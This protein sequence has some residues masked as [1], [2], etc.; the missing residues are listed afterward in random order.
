MHRVAIAL[1]ALGLLAACGSGND[2]SAGGGNT[3]SGGASPDIQGA[4]ELAEGTADNTDLPRPDGA[5]ATLDVEA[6]QLSGQSFCNRFF[7]GYRLDGDA[8]TIDLPGVTMMA[9]EPEVMTAESVFLTALSKVTTAAREGEELLL[10]GGGVQLRFTP[11]VPVP[12]RDLAGTRWVLET[13]LDGQ[14]ASS[15]VG[16]PA[17]LVLDTDRTVE[18]TT[19]CR[20]ITGTWLIEGDALV[21]DDLLATGEC[22][23]DVIGQDERVAAVLDGGSGFAIEGDQLTLTG[24]DGRGLIY[25]AEG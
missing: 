2:S 19:G 17:V 15:T 24:Q 18:A 23:A 3:G 9:C 8:L 12:D 4:W 22:T 21:V 6:D 20:T 16:E 1:L 7:A 25:R 11:V 10:S 14:G 13:V 5:A